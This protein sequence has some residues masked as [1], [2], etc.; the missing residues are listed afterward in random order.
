M[1]FGFS[2]EAFGNLIVLDTIIALAIGGIIF[3]VAH[4]RGIDVTTRRFQLMLMVSC[5]LI[6]IIIPLWLTDITIKWKAIITVAGFAA[7]I[8][9]YFVIDRMQRVLRERL[10][11]K[12][13]RENRDSDE[14]H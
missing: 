10:G 6:L 4:K 7:G 5:A 9:N 11:D 13:E 1:K 8:G 14:W 2:G 3:I 12:K